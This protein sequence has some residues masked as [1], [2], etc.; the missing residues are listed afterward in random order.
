MELYFEDLE[1]GRE[2]DCG[3]FEIDEDEIISFAEQYDPQPYHTDPEAAESSPFG[4]IISSGWMTLC[5]STR[6]AVDAFRKHVATMGGLGI[7]GLRWTTPVR[8]G[9]ALTVRNVVV[10]KR[11]SE[12]DPTR[13]LMHEKVMV[14][15]QHGERVLT[16][17]VISLVQR[18]PDGAADV[19]DTS[20]SDETS[21]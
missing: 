18:T 15:N 2:R 10:D 3:T 21:S 7:D 8:P 13:G 1:I 11:I 19:D 6:L 5:R 9:D 4:G 20:S 17:V 12:S 14:E 16:Y